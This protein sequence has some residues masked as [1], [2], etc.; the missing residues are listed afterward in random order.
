MIYIINVLL[1]HRPTVKTTDIYIEVNNSQ[2]LPSNYSL[3]TSWYHGPIVVTT[4]I[5]KQLTSYGFLPP[6]AF[7]PPAYLHVYVV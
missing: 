1:Y 7:L 2:S 6:A 3:P 4:D 5:T